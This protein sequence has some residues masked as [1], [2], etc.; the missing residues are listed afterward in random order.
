[1]QKVLIVHDI[2][3]YGKCSTTVALPIL[4]A[5]ELTGTLLPTALLSTHTGPGFE[6]FTFLDLTQ[7]MRKIVDHWISI[8]LKFQAIYIGYLGN[9]EQ[10][11]FLQEVCPHILAEGGKV[12]LDPVMADNGKFYHGFDQ[13][14]AD[15]MIHLARLADVVMPNLTEAAFIYGTPYQAGKLSSEFLTKVADTIQADTDASIV[16]TGAG[17]DEAAGLTG[18]YFRDSQSGTSGLA[19]AKLISGSFH[20]TGDIFGSILVGSLMQ[21]ASLETA[22]T[23]ATEMLPIMLETSLNNPNIIQDGLDFERYSGELNQFARQLQA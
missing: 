16:L 11:H 19:Q 7:E 14:Y 1:M 6:N 22:T 15:E 3:C 13:T 12:Y 9:V 5:M 20:G 17:I 23:Y 18:T 21:G 8:D 10:I 4:S 2:S